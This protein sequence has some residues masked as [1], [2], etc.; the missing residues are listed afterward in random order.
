MKAIIGTRNQ[1]KVEGAKLA[2]EKFFDNIEIVSVSVESEVN[3][4]PIN[5]EIIQGAK[6]RIK[7]LKKY[8][9][10]NDIKVDLYMSIESGMQNLFG[11]WMITNIAIIE[12]NNNVQSISTSSSFPLPE[13]YVEDTKNMNL[14]EVMNKVFEKDEN[15][16]KKGGG[17]ELLTHGEI[18]RIDITKEAFVMSLTKF[19]NG[20]KWK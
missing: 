8:C 6:N 7:N 18:S 13:K 16:H 12:N 20:E 10:E 15:R 14:N 9:K 3:E 5:L 4:Q 17:I 19:I 1:G 11:E 2:L